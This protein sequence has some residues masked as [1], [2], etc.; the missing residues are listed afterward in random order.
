MFRL[1]D[2]TSFNTIF[3]V[4]RDVEQGVVNSDF[5]MVVLVSIIGGCTKNIGDWYLKIAYFLS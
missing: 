1:H 2:R 4:I 5:K 3:G